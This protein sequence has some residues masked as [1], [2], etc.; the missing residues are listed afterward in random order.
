MWE[1]QILLIQAGVPVLQIKKRDRL[2]LWHLAVVNLVTKDRAAMG[3]SSVVPRPLLVAGAA[4]LAALAALLALL[5]AAPV[6]VEI[7]IGGGGG[8]CG[9]GHP[10][11]YRVQDAVD[12]DVLGLGWGMF[13]ETFTRLDFIWGKQESMRSMRLP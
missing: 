10:H 13:G 9:L 4:A 12:V 11:L 7:A 8:A 6:V 2:Q 3:E 1:G 5:V